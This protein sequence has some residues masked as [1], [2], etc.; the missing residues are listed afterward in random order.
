MP[1]LREFQKGYTPVPYLAL[2]TGYSHVDSRAPVQNERFALPADLSEAFQKVCLLDSRAQSC[3]A[4]AGI[5]NG[6]LVVLEAGLQSCWVG[7]G[8]N[9]GSTRAHLV[10]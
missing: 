3:T 2:L 5:Y 10:V 1:T 7:D 8:K 4:V 9:V 6:A